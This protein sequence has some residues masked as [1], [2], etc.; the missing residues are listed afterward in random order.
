[1]VIV[2][3]GVNRVA[4]EVAVALLLF[5]MVWFT[6][7]L[8]ALGTGALRRSPGAIR[9]IGD[10]RAWRGELTDDPGATP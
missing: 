7:K 5:W 8:L 3:V 1:V 4:G 9:R 10:P 6:A 2:A